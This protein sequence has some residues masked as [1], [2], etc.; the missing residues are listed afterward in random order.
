MQATQQPLIKNK[1][2]IVAL[3]L[4]IICSVTSLSLFFYMVANINSC[5]PWNACT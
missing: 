2:F 5:I 3:I 1:F 4:A